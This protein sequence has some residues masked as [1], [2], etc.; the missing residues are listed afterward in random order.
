VGWLTL[1][2][3]AWQGYA[4]EWF[5]LAY[6]LCLLPSTVKGVQNR[7]IP[8]I[9]ALCVLVSVVALLDQF[10]S[11]V[12]PWANPTIWTG[13]VAMGAAISHI[14]QSVLSLAKENQ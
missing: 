14:L 10:Q 3:A 5:T 8:L 11:S 1:A 6:G 13:C 7:N 2:L 12:A 4:F 9:P